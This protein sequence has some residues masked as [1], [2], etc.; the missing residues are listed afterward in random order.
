M[1]GFSLRKPYTMPRREIRKAAEGLVERLQ[2][3]HPVRCE[4]HGDSVRLKGAGVAGKLSFEGDVIDVSVKLGMLMRPFQKPL[5][6]EV[7]RYLDEH[8]Y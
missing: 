5:K 2:K 6:A 7:Q 1:S 3:E 4:W 8:V